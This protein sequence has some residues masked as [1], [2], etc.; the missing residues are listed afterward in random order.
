ML[1][2]TLLVGGNTLGK[3]RKGRYEHREGGTGFRWLTTLGESNVNHS[4]IDGRINGSR[5]WGA[6]AR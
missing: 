1:Q 2:T 5:G 6:S 4:I 3:H